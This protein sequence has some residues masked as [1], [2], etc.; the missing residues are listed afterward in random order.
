MERRAREERGGSEVAGKA[1]LGGSLGGWVFG[2]FF[3][4]KGLRYGGLNCLLCD[5]LGNV[6]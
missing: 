5:F 1:G 2:K 4:E 3:E 6:F